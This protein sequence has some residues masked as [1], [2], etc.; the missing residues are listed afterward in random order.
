[1]GLE[2]ED[3]LLSK[4]DEDLPFARHVFGGCEFLHFV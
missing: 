1:M 3:G 4:V 2:I